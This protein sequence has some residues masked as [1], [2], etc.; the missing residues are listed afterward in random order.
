MFSK[1]QRLNTSLFDEVFNFGKNKSSQ[2]F[3]LKYKKNDLGVPRFGITISKKKVS[4]AVKRHFVK[5]KFI[6]LLKESNL[7]KRSY[8]MVFILN[9]EIES[10]KKEDLILNINKIE[11]E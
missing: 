8:D 2:Y 7:I 10:V 4:S 1:K 5:R 6:N 11:L 9:K 3:L